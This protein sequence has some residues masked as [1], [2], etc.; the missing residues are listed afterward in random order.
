MKPFIIGV[1]GSSGSGK[2]TI[3]AELAKKYRKKC[4]VISADSYY[5]GRDLMPEGCSFDDPRAIDFDLLV[6]HLGE[7]K[8]GNAIEVPIYD[9]PTSQRTQQTR[10]V[11]P[12]KI[13]I[14]EGILVLYPEALRQLYEISIFVETNLE[15]CRT[16]RL[17]RD[18]NERG[19]TR[20]AAMAQWA[21]VES[22]Y[23]K[24]VQPTQHYADITIENS[25][26]NLCL[27]FDVTPVINDL[28]AVRK[29]EDS[30]LKGRR[31]YSIYEK[32]TPDSEDVELVPPIRPSSF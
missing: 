15:V 20:D 4:V 32:N 28:N 14:V 30:A 23:I 12:T 6:E 22:Y 1:A 24:Y 2:T 27:E 5:L 19:R 13:I 10:R 18:I 7:L 11:L 9:F 31:N 8:K 16:R 29:N 21:E 26:E 25:G 17:E 3:S